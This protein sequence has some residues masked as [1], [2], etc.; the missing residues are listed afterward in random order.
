M[1]CVQVKLNEGR[2]LLDLNASLVNL[3]LS[4]AALEP[5]IPC[6]DELEQAQ[7]GLLMGQMMVPSCLSCGLWL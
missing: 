4:P 1:G 6:T 2:D 7:V 3:K 5:F